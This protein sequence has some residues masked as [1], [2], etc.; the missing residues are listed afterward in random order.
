MDSLTQATLGAAIGE[1]ILGRKLGNRAIAWGAFLGTLPDLDVLFSPLLNSS[2]NLWWH[3]GPSHSL[4]LMILISWW[5]SR[6]L[7]KLW[8]RDK[9]SRS[10]AGWFVF[11]AWS[12]HVVIDCFT[13]YG[14]SLWWPLPWRTAWNNLFI[15]D[16][17]FTA[18]MLVALVWLAFL[19]D[20]KQLAKRRRLNAWGL[21]LACLYV[22]FS[23]CMKAVADSRFDGDLARR[24]ITP[25]RR[26]EAPTPF[27]TLLWRSVADCGDAFWIADVSVFDPKGEAITWT[28]VP[29]HHEALDGIGNQP[30]IKRLAWFSDGWFIARPNVKGAWIGDVRFGEWR[31]WGVKDGMVDLRLV[32]AWMFAKDKPGDRLIALRPDGMD[33]GAA[34]GRIARRAIGDRDSWEAEPRLVGIKGSMPEPLRTVK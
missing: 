18:P 26:F 25:L 27:N 21:G 1:L 23:F 6:P 8:K 14:T 9:V 5:L 29:K 19:R 31:T 10:R 15:I 3:R 13:V 22:A 7:A 16:P 24:G 4:V 30:E 33:V 12:T 20:K 2:W 17:L 11:A 34:L 32:F 28:I